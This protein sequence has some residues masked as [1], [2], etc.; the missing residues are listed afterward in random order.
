MYYVQTTHFEAKADADLANFTSISHMISMD[1]SIDESADSSVIS[2]TIDLVAF[3]SD[4][5]IF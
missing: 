2:N 4:F 1:T 5:T 3:F